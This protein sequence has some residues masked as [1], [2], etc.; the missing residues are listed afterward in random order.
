[1]SYKDKIDKY[2]G[3]CM[4]LLGRH[5][6]F[7]DYVK[8]FVGLV[9]IGSY[10]LDLGT[11]PGGCNASFFILSKLD[12][13]DAEPEVLKSLSQR[14]YN[15]IFPFVFGKDT[16]P[17]PDLTLNFVVCSCVIQHLNSFEELVHGLSEI[18]RVLKPGGYFY[19]M[20]KVGTN[21]TILTHH[22]SHYD[23]ERSF[24]VF[25]PK[26]VQKLA[27]SLSFLLVRSEYLLDDNHI[28]YSCDVYMRIEYLT[29]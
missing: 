17:Y 29:N 23:E 4:I 24:R 14:L 7:S 3:D 13:C 9:R 8:E 5:K 2:Q 25:C 22:N 1:M 20:Y 6:K 15:K 27:A 16:L 18:Y 19:L 21:D 28:P 11:G 12:G 26:D 10:G